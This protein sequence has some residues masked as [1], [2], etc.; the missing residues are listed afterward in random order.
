[1]I[2]TKK[3]YGGEITLLQTKIEEMCARTHTW[4]TAH[5]FEPLAF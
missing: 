2:I 5:I 1:M 3:C 4:S